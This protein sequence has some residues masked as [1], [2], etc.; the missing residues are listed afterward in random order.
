MSF[1]L[2]VKSSRSNAS[3]TVSLD[4][5]SMRSLRLAARSAV[6]F[7]LI[8]GRCRAMRLVIDE[9]AQDGVGVVEAPCGRR[10]LETRV[11]GTARR[12][13]RG[14]PRQ[15]DEGS[16]RLCFLTARTHPPCRTCVRRSSPER[17]V[18]ARASFPERAALKRGFTRGHHRA[19]VTGTELRH[20]VMPFFLRKRAHV[21]HPS[22]PYYRDA[23]GQRK[24]ES[25]GRQVPHQRSGI[26]QDEIWASLEHLRAVS[27]E[28]HKS[29]YAPTAGV[30]ARRPPTARKVLLSSRTDAVPSGSQILSGVR[31]RRPRHFLAQ[32][33]SGVLGPE[34][35]ELRASLS[36]AAIASANTA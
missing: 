22:A 16:G 11:A 29:G 28:D 35:L 32:V 27:V 6:L 23:R 31:P 30:E 17:T 21:A 25:V 15:R 14:R 36:Q 13:R 5:G 33:T 1:S 8:G 12:I 26:G 24:R 2:M 10:R 3:G 4:R 7:Y 9:L 20:V 18:L 19:R 34:R